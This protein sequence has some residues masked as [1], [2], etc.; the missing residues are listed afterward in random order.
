MS[1]LLESTWLG[2]VLFF[3]M[4][5]IPSTLLMQWNH[6]WREKQLIKKLTVMNIIE[7]VWDH[8][9]RERKKKYSL[10]LKKNSWKCWK[11]P[12]IIYQKFTSK[13]F[14]TVSPKKFKMC[15][16][17]REVKKWWKLSDRKCH[18]KRTKHIL[19][20]ILF[21]HILHLVHCFTDE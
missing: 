8:L 16:M 7:A 19:F 5:T 10:N 1:F 15:L 17:P 14:R 13:N 21:L 9:E 18:F 20:L 11:K 4:I 3:S 6:V 2:M 12:G